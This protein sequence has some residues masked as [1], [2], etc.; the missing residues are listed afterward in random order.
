MILKL[1][2][3]VPKLEVFRAVAK[4]HVVYVLVEFVIVRRIFSNVS[5]QNDLTCFLTQIKRLHH[6][7]DVFHIFGKLSDHKLIVI[8]QLPLL[9][10][11]NVKFEP[12][13]KNI[14]WIIFPVFRDPGDAFNKYGRLMQ[15]NYLQ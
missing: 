11:D 7:H 13:H 9:C 8:D 1:I 15:K 14:K 12:V 4:D 2:K 6:Q 10:R 3:H 5:P